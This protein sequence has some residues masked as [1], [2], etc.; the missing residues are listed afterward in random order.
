MSRDALTKQFLEQLASILEA[1]NESKIKSQTSDLSDVIDE[2]NAHMLIT[3]ARAAIARISGP[4]SAYSKQAQDLWER[5]GEH[6][7]GRLAQII[8]VVKSLQADLKAGYL[9]S[10]EELIHAEVFADFLE[11]A[12]HLQSEGYKDAAAVLASGSLEA[13]L[14]QLCTKNGIAIEVSTATG[15]QPKKADQ[16]NADL[17]KA[18]IYS[19]LDQKNVTAWLDL[20]NKA[21]HGHYGDYTKEQVTLLIAGVRDFI[22][23]SPA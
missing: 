2:V 12:D 21:A 10:L 13:H 14:R 3:K 15:I 20:R 16:M 23:R 5:K 11:M 1:Y 22:T 18:G 19:K 6:D 17:A 8:G 7:W 9:A 4:E